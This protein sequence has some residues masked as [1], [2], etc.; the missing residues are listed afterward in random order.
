MLRDTN[1]LEQDRDP[2]KDTAIN[3]R[4]GNAFMSDGKLLVVIK[5]EI[6]Q[7]GKG[8]SVAQIEARDP[9]TGNKTNLRFRTQE[10]IERADLFESDHQYL[11]EADDTY[12]FMNTESFEQVEVSGELIG[13]P[14]AYLQE[15]MICAVQTHEGTPISVTLPKSVIME[16]VEA[17]PVVKGQTQSSSYKPAMLENGERILVPPHIE[18][19]TRVV[20]NVAEGAYVERAKD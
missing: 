10:T 13:N 20:V 9:L 11:F 18:T 6:N 15:G 3:L 4:A 5:N 17:D 12:T 2:M 8:A 19:G 7:P 1:R 14:K 16:I